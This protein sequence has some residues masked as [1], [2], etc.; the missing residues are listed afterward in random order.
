MG[1]DRVEGAMTLLNVA[2]AREGTKLFQLAGMLVPQD[3]RF[4]REREREWARKR[5]CVCERE[6]DRWRESDSVNLC[7]RG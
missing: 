7:V 6:R 2:G 3:P 4:G 1:L 5:L